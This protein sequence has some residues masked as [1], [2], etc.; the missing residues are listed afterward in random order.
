MLLV[1]DGA[2]RQG[3]FDQVLHFVDVLLAGYDFAVDKKCRCPQD[4]VF[5][6]RAALFPGYGALV[7]RRIQTSTK[8]FL[9]QS[10]RCG[11]LHEGRIDIVLPS[12]VA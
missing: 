1:L 9:I 7:P 3:P 4:T 12:P 5:P 11:L 2:I 6:A 8:R 10:D